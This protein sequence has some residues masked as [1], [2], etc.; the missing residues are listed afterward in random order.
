[1]PLLMAYLILL[2]IVFL[3]RTYVQVDIILVNVLKMIK[4]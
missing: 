4:C 3:I 2:G 1:M